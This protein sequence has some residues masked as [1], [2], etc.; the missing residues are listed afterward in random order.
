V[1]RQVDRPITVRTLVYEGSAETCYVPDYADETIPRARIPELPPPSTPPRRDAAAAAAAGG[2]AASERPH[3]RPR[4]EPAEALHDLCAMAPQLEPG[5]RAARPSAITG[6]AHCRRRGGRRLSLRL[7]RR[8]SSRI[9]SGN[10]GVCAEV[11]HRLRG[12]FAAAARELNLLEQM[13]A[14]LA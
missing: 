13:Q 8:L 10:P 2:G 14:G 1:A 9:V 3:K 12:D 11:L 5:A 7:R 6:Y 4:P